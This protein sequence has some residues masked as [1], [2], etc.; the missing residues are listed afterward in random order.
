V[1]KLEITM[2]HERAR[3]AWIY[4]AH[5]QEAMSKLREGLKSLSREELEELVAF[6]ADYVNV[7]LREG[8]YMV[9][10]DEAV[11]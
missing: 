4:A 7:V 6:A 1:V 8:E 2:Q 5:H 3:E 10:R 11:E 9:V